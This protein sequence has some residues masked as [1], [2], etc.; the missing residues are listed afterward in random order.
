MSDKTVRMAWGISL[1]AE[2]ICVVILSFLNIFEVDWALRIPL[3]ILIVI[4]G[5]VMLAFS[6]P[7]IKRNRKQKN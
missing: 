2:G 3:C 4:S 5:V 6:V 7:L 1:M